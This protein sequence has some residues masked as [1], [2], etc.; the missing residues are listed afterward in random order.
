MSRQMASAVVV[1]TQFK[2]ATELSLGPVG[3]FLVVCSKRPLIAFYSK[4][5]VGSRS[6]SQDKGS[7]QIITR[8]WD[9]R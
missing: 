2:L 8:E 9:Y 6:E 7:R 5:Y 4:T 3:G 1:D